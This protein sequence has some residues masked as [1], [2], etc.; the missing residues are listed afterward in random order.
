MNVLVFSGP[1]FADHSVCYAGWMTREK[2]KS[3][4]VF[5]P[6]SVEQKIDV[7]A[8][9]RNVIPVVFDL[10]E[11]R[12]IW[13]DLATSS[14]AFHY[15]NNVESNRASIEEK[16][17]AIVESQNKLSLYELFELHAIARGQLVGDKDKA[18]TV[19]SLNEGIGPYHINDINADYI[20]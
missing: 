10:Q 18:D 4:E 12:A 6:A 1:N 17:K 16:L 11:R 5:E 13:V 8:A 9:C 19:F 2:P 3:N 15:G 7:R 14:N 20:G